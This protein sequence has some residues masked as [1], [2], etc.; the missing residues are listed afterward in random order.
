MTK[1]YDDESYPY[2]PKQSRIN[3]SLW[4]I[5]HKPT[6]TWRESPRYS[7]DGANWRANEMNTANDAAEG[8]T[9]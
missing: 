3:P 2:R 9:W 1:F 8:G 4:G 7:E 5:E 6:G